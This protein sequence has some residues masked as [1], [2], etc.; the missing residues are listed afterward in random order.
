[1]LQAY[2]HWFG[3]ALYAEESNA[4]SLFIPI[5]LDSKSLGAEDPTEV[6]FARVWCVGECCG[7]REDGEKIVMVVERMFSPKVGLESLFQG[8]SQE[9]KAGWRCVATE[10]EKLVAPPSS[11]A[12]SS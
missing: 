10:C 2:L 11:N 9:V 4:V 5:F 1:M 12:A 3:V 7:E 8:Q 6:S